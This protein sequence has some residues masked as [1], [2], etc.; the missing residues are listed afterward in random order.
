MID[1]SPPS[2]PPRLIRSVPAAAWLPPG[3]TAEVWA[4]DDLEVPPPAVIVRL[5]IFRARELYCVRTPRG[6]DLPTLFLDGLS[7][8][9]GVSRLTRQH[10]PTAPGGDVPTRC[11]GY[12]RNIVP[13]PD[14]SYR[15]PAP[16]AH[17]PVFTP[18]DPTLDPARGHRRLDQCR[19]GPGSAGR[20]ALVA[21]RPRGPRPDGRNPGLGGRLVIETSP[22]SAVPGG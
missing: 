19:T 1:S 3:S 22:S 4:G 10:L 11:I 7:P 18:R 8:M 6:F 12:V 21:H 16:L 20:T 2:G 14:E 15:L 9:E 17:V 13:E 5:A